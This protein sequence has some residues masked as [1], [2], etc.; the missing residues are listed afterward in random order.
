MIERKSNIPMYIQI[1]E[2]LKSEIME[3]ESSDILMP[4]Q[5]ELVER[6]DV[7]LITIR[8]AMEIL[9]DEDYIIR[10]PGKGTFTVDKAYKDDMNALKTVSEVI[11]RGPNTTIKVIQ[12]E[13]RNVENVLSSDIV[14]AIGQKCLYV[15]RLHRD[16]GEPVC[17]SEI[18]I[19]EKFEDIIKK[20]RL[21]KEATYSTFVNLGGIKL[22]KGKQSIM[23]RK[24]SSLVSTYLN[25]K[26][27]SPILRIERLSL[28]DIGNPFEFIKIYYEYSKYK[29]DI[30]LELNL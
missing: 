2:R 3:Y 19:P 28:D 9:E 1:A 27:N 13:K 17:L 5:K 26:E 6:F 21:E 10:K 12:M 7:S 15:L 25:V 11:S 18:F 14:D 22:G 23:A 20:D 29:I 16:N 4:S 24:A 8:K 30:D